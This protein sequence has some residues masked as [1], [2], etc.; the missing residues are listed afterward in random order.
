MFM[1][2]DDIITCM[3]EFRQLPRLMSEDEQKL[4]LFVGENVLLS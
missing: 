2:L 3:I 4:L 1:V